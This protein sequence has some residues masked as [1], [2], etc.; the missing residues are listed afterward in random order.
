MAKAKQPSYALVFAGVVTAFFVGAHFVEERRKKIARGLAKKRP[1]PP[2]LL[3]DLDVEQLRTGDYVAELAVGD[4]M[5]VRAKA[6]PSAGILWHSAFEG[7]GAEGSP[8]AIKST[9]E[10]FGEGPGSTMIQKFQLTAVRVG[11]ATVLLT[12]TNP[13]NEVVDSVRFHVEVME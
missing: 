1:A 3:E 12:A 5:Q 4:A 7:V 8:V 11:S 6:N 13:A 9:S 10:Q 2:A